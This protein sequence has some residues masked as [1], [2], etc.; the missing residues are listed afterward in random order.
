M[1]E[2]LGRRLKRQAAEIAFP[3][4][5]GSEGNRRAR[6]MVRDRFVAA[7][8]EVE[9]QPFSYDLERAFRAI[10]WTLRFVAL[11]VAVAALLAASRI[12]LAAVALAVAILGGG[13]LLAWAPG[14]EK[15]YAAEG[16]TR[17]SNVVARRR[18]TGKRRKT[19]VVLAH[20]DSKSQNL[21]FPWR[22]GSTLVAILGTLVLAVYL[23]APELLPVWF[24]QAGGAA[25]GVALALLSTL[26][27]ENRSPGGVDNAGS[28]ALLTE[29]ARDLPGALPDDVELILL[30]PSAEEDHMVGAMR[31]LDGNLDAERAACDD[32]IAINMDGAGIPGRAAAMR[33]FGFGQHFGPTIVRAAGEASTVLEIPMRFIWLPPAIGV[34]AIPFVHRGIECVTFTSGSL[35]RA[36]M[37]VHS[38]GD[39]ADN[40]S[41]R[42]LEEVYRLVRETVCRLAAA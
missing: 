5:A 3:R 39:V 28:V 35:G 27:N 25:A 16:R 31:W 7:G 34:D 10:R 17:T 4:G 9:E 24:G 19:L 26:R 38:D 41:E 12:G 33:W 18:A 36:T 15:L 13:V 20:Y 32:I 6:R 22:M 30:A 11:S 29:L 21:T 1:S 14:I 40:L 23:I 8:L 37:A 2:P 42:A